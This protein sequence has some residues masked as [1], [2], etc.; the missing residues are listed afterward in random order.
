[1]VT[2]VLSVLTLFRG[3]E[4]PA[5]INTIKDMLAGLP[6]FQE[7][8]EAYSLHLTMTQDAMSVFQERKLADVASVEQVGRKAVPRKNHLQLTGLVAGDWP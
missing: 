6:K 8:K 5:T 4:G 2:T 1:M 7:G 3:S